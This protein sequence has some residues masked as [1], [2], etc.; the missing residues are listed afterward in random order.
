GGADDL[1]QGGFAVGRLALGLAASERAG[2]GALGGT[3]GTECRSRFGAV[4]AHRGL[5]RL[6]CCR[7]AER[8]G[9]RGLFR[10]GRLGR[11]GGR[12]GGGRL[13]GGLRGPV[14][15]RGAHLGTGGGAVQLGGLGGRGLAL[16]RT[17]GRRPR[18]R[19]RHRLLGRTEE[20]IVVE[21]DRNLRRRRLSRTAERGLGCRLG[22]GRRLLLEHLGLDL[23]LTTVG[24]GLLLLRRFGRNLLLDHRFRGDRLLQR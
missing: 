16:G 10:R 8:G 24:L 19:G 5:G 7:R 14:R 4:D 2:L 21:R 15:G 3:E 11:C 23:G 6:R 9:G 20:H 18:G 13:R 1:V 12:L 22:G 17:V